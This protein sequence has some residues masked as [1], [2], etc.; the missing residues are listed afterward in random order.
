MK[1]IKVYL[2]NVSDLFRIFDDLDKYC[3]AVISGETEEVLSIANTLRESWSARR[4]D[5]TTDCYIELNSISD[6]LDIVI[7]VNN[8]IN[9]LKG[10]TA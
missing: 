8:Y 10:E 6:F 2:I 5:N 9:C 1:S 4:H 7:E 3:L